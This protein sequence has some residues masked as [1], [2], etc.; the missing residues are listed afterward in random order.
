M[1]KLTPLQAET[2]EFCRNQIDEARKQ[3]VDITKTKKKR[4]CRCKKDFGCSK[5]NRLYSRR[6]LHNSYIKEIRET[7]ID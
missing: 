6:E 2:M 4:L 5:R 7:W 1:N 3:V